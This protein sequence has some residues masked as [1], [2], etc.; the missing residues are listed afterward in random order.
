MLYEDNTEKVVCGYEIS[1]F[2]NMKVEP[3]TVTVIYKGYDNLC[4]NYK[5]IEDDKGF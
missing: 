1:G 4:Y 3:Q 5:K 2:D